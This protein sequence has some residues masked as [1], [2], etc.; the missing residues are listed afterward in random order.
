MVALCRSLG[1]SGAGS[2]LAGLGYAF[3]APGLLLYGNVIFLV[4]AAWLPW[5]LR[6]IDRLLR[7]QQRSA[8]AGLATV[9]ALQVLGGDPEA[10]YLTCLAGAGYGIALERVTRPG[11]PSRWVW[12][13]VSA[14]LCVWVSMTLGLASARPMFPVWLPPQVCLRSCRPPGGCWGLPSS[15]G[16]LSTAR[17]GPLARGGLPGWPGRA[18]GRSQ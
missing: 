6:A 5:G 13:L 2:M 18:P 9:L 10:A 14:A 12:V 17:G 7:Q 15:G 16:W 1:V 3:G 11:S 8:V 4:G